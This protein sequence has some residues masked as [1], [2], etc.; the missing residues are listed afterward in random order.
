MNDTQKNNPLVLNMDK[1]PGKLSEIECFFLRNHD[2]SLNINGQKRGTL[3]R[4]SPLRGNFAACAMNQP[5]GENYTTGNY[6]SPI[7]NETYSWIYNSNGVHFIQRINGDGICEVVYHGCL[8]LSAEPEHSIDQFKAYLKVDKI[9]ANTPGGVRKLLVFTDGINDLGCID[10]EVSIATNFFNTPFFERCTDPCELIRLCVPDP[11]GCVLAE[12]IDPTPEDAGLKNNLLDVGIRLAYRHVYYDGIRKSTYSDPSKLLYQDTR[13]CFNNGTF[14]RCIKMRV[15]VGNALVE[16][17]EII[18]YKEGQ[19]FLH[20][21]VEKYKKY[22]DAQEFWYERELSEQVED[23]FS[24]TDCA[25]DYEFCMD[26]QCLVIDINDINRVYNPMPRQVQCLFEIGLGE[27]KA[28]LAF[29]NYVK[30][31]CAI[32]A[33]EI[34]KISVSADCDNV[35]CQTEMVEL[36][37]RAVI[38]NTEFHRNQPIF[39]LGGGVDNAADDDTDIAFFGGLNDV[40]NG[41]L[42]L[43][44]G[45]QFREKVR[46]FIV[47][48]EGTEYWAEMKQWKAD[49]YFTN[50]TEWGT[51]SNLEDDST[52]RRWRRAIKD[53]DFFYQEAKIKVPKGMRGFIRITS[54]ESTTPDDDKSTFVLG[55]LTGIQNYAGNLN[56]NSALDY[57]SEEIYFNACNPDTEVVQDFFVIQDNAV[58]GG[59]STKASAFHGYLKDGN[60]LPVEGALI[61]V[62]ANGGITIVAAG[63]TDHNGF[64]HCYAYPGLTEDVIIEAR[65]E[66]DCDTEFEQL[67]SPQVSAF[68]GD[69]ILRNIT[70][71]DEEYETNFLATV[72]MRAIDC[73]GNAIAGVKVA[74]SGSKY[75][76]TASDGV[77]TFKIRNYDTRAREVRTIMM[78]TNSCFA[79][80]CGNN[81]N[82]CMPQAVKAT[83]ACYQS[84]PTIT[85]ADGVLNRES[86]VANTRG[87]KNGGAYPMGIVAKGTCGRQSPVYNIGT[88]NIPKVQ[89]K[90]REGFC[91]AINYTDTGAIFPD[92]VNCVDI[93]RGEN[94]NPFELQWVVDTIERTDDGKIKL[95]IQSLIDYNEKYLFKTN[96]I[97]SWLAGDRI[98]FIKNGDGKIFSIAQHGLLSYLAVSPFHDELVSGE[99]EAETDFFNQLLIIDD[100][101][102]SD[103]EEGAVIEIQRSKQCVNEPTYFGICVSIPVV[104][105]ALQYPEG[106]FETFDT[107]YVKRKIGEFPSQRFEHHSPSDFWG[108]RLTDAGRPYFENKFENERR[109]GRNVTVSPPFEINRFGDIE[110]PLN[111]D[112]HGD[113]IA[114]I[115][116]D[117]RI[118]IAISENDNSIFQVADDIARVA[119]DGT[120]RASSGGVISEP[121][122]K[123]AGAFGC[124]YELA[125]GIQESDGLITWFD[126]YSLIKHDYNIAKA[127]DVDKV[128]S[129][130]TFK[131]QELFGHNKEQTDPLNKIRVCAGL[132][133]SNNS[134]HLTFKTLRD[135]AY[136]NE[137]NPFSKR[138]ETIVFD[139]Y[140]E[141][142]LTFAGFTA[143]RYG[144]LE[145]ITEEDPDHPEYGRGCAFIAY[146]KGVP[147]IFP[148][149]ATRFNEFF[150]VPCD[151]MIGMV[152]NKNDS[153]VKEPLAIEQQSGETFFFVK[154]VLTENIN[155]RS[156][157]PP[158]RWV[159][160]RNKWN[161]AFLANK[162]NRGGIY[163]DDKPVGYYTKVLFVRDNT[164][165]LKYNTV[166]NAKRIAY[167]ELDNIFFKFKIMEQSGFTENV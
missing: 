109:Y 47:Y 144:V 24:E 135:P 128:S 28:A 112:S 56:I 65:V 23:T 78:N 95:T 105:G 33:K 86:V 148:I 114:V 53:G 150:G 125:S 166:D 26:K 159:K 101:K 98:E 154:E 143:E 129:W 12:F 43:T 158:A 122:P 151:W 22:N 20:D 127:I 15:P 81:C 160:D 146:F 52:K 67:A 42:E 88:L 6:Y 80:D 120:I 70:I 45:Q 164:D 167:S 46:N 14:S 118:G 29:V 41:D 54:H 79:F 140:T 16:K 5:G 108:T 51:L 103:L 165:G 3:G 123:I 49:S 36:T 4:T 72:K 126:G 55:T 59:L 34:Q 90:N 62:V 134:I 60:G 149:I 2:R 57:Y 163:G 9:C 96:T 137:I 21:T 138:N 7:T 153:K 102:L 121:Q 89:E 35:D 17:I 100:G 115:I 85:M 94:L 141:D 76:T 64:Y 131:G 27:D 75:K 124:P 39:R 119:D 50:I 61:K 8:Q 110:R 44:F 71:E 161:A 68:A 19:W 132:N 142:F 37:V 66:R 136:N 32:D 92:W 106:F 113:I 77:A 11:C 10:V 25:F 93:V 1:S 145:L 82:P 152:V 139:P 58:D 31:T 73:I 40:S 13:G 130:F 107:Y 117:N 162:L 157:I 84:N 69:N 99:D 83:P 91:G 147:Y 18:Y 155:F 97:Y 104:N 111:P 116:K 48:I 74:I 156:E 87:L 133:W 38:H 30:G 63:K